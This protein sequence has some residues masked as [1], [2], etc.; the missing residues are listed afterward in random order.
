MIQ[1]A[2]WNATKRSIKKK[3]SQSK[4]KIAY[5][6]PD[7]LEC[8]LQIDRVIKITLG[9]EHVENTKVHAASLM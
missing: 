3:M 8:G 6:C 2:V 4:S 1:R 9:R 7:A 5:I